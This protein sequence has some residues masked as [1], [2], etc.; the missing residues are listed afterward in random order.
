MAPIRVG[1]IGLTVGDGKSLG[2]GVWGI[3]AHLPTYT[4][5]PNY[6]IVALCN[7]SVDAAKQSIAYHKLPATTKAYGSPEDI[8]NDPDVDLV[9][10]SVHV[11]R[12]HLL[13]LPALKAKKQVFCEWPLG[14]TTAEAEEMAQLAKGLKVVT[15]LQFRADPLITKAKQ[16]VDSGA[17]GQITSTIATGCFNNYPADTWNAKADYFLNFKGGANEYTISFA[18]FLDSFRYIVG[19]FASLQSVLDIQY[20]TVKLIDFTTGEVTDPARKKTSPDHIFVNGKLK[21]GAVASLSFRK[22]TKTVDGKGLR[23]FISGTKG[24]LEITIDGPNFQMDIAKKQ[25]RLVDNSVGVTQDIDFTDAQELAYVKSVPVMGQNTSRL[26]EK[27][28]AAPT[29]VANFDDALKLHQLLD[30]IAAAV[31]YPYKA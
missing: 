5:S 18:H 10:V 21:S 15:G 28:V 17:I 12:H 8:A 9:V 6:E 26:C 23:W 2:N 31:D 29:E 25:L 13:A 11:S 19:D 7:S 16:L 1:L 24:E 14:A 27:F 20:P 30:K 22:V 4:N 3:A